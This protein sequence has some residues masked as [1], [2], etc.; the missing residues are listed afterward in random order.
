MDVRRNRSLL[1]PNLG[2]SQK[3]LF[4]VISSCVHT[5][6]QG[7]LHNCGKLVN[8]R[9]DLIAFSRLDRIRRFSSA[10]FP[11]PHT[12]PCQSW[13]KQVNF[14]RLLTDNLTKLCVY[15][16]LKAPFLHK[17]ALTNVSQKI[18]HPKN[19]SWSWNLT[20]ETTEFSPS[21]DYLTTVAGVDWGTQVQWRVH[22]DW[23]PGFGKSRR[24]ERFF[25]CYR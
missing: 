9:F 24:T 12:P 1:F 25:A 7:M 3:N 10:F 19:I 14:I 4:G 16:R 23:Q 17:E 15:K 6:F 11:S 22:W 5:Q 8:T 20:Y 2:V 21:Q 13:L 18:F